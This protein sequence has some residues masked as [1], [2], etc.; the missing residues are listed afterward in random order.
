M[1]IFLIGYMGCGKTTQAQQLAAELQLQF[2][3]LDAEIVREYGKD[4][5]AIFATDG[6]A[7][8]R[9]LERQELGEWLERDN[10]V[11]A[12]GGGT[13][14][15]FDNMDRMNDA[16]ITIYLKMSADTLF[17]RLRHERATRPLIADL[18]DNALL[19]SIHLGLEERED[20]YHLAQYRVKA[21]GLETAQLT[22][23]LRKEAAI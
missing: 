20:W 16:G 2:V 9:D 17:D 14:C 6:E 5:P 8:F 12:C 11:M 4:I 7:H 23:F 21:K 19:D 1:R 15:F 13:P 3:D 22:Q 18:D 10:F